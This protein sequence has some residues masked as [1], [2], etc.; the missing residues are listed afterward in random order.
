M[1]SH[2]TPP[3]TPGR[4]E[5][6]SAEGQE[7]IRAA[8][9]DD[10]DLKALG[11]RLA[12][13]PSVTLPGYFP[14]DF[15]TR[16]REN[17]REILAAYRATVAAARAGDLI[18]PAAEW[19]A[20]NHYIVE[21]N[22]RA[23]YRD[24]P[25]RFYRQLPAIPVEGGGEMPRCLA[26]AWLYVAHMHGTLSMESLAKMVEGFQTVTPLMIGEIWA[27]PSALRFV[28][29]ENL[30]RHSQ[31]VERARRMRRRANDAADRL[32]ALEDNASC[33]D[34]LSE[35]TDFTRDDTFVA[36]LLYRLR[37]GSQTS[38]QALA[39]LEERLEERDSDSEE[40]LVSE[41]NRVATSNVTTG[42]II[43]SLRKIND[44]EWTG[45]FEEISQVDRILRQ[46]ADFSEIDFASRD[47]YRTVI[48]RLAR[49]S[50][51]TEIEVARLVLD[52]VEADARNGEAGNI[53]FY[54]AGEKRAAIEARIGYRPR[55]RDIA[56]NAYRRLDWAGIAAPVAAI[57]LVV[58]AL[59]AWYLVGF[60]ELPAALVVILVL[61]F[62][63]P[64]SEAANGLFHALAT[65][66][67]LPTRLIGYE[68]KN[69]IPAEAHTLVAIP[70]LIGSKDTVDE[71]LRNLEVHYLA[72]PRGAISFALLSDWPDS[73]QEETRH[74][75]EI[76]D[77]ARRQ[78]ERLNARYRQGGR[79][80]FFL[81]HRRRVYNP[82]ENVWMGWE[83][84]RGKLHELNLLLRGDP[85]TTFLQ[86]ERRPPQ[87][88]RF[89]MTLDSDT[90]LTR[91]AVTKLVGKMAHPTNRPRL[92]PA[93]GIVTQGYGI[94]Q[95]RVTPSLT[96]GEEA[97]A[98]QR[99]FSVNRGLDPYV[100]TISDA[101][102]DLL[103]EGSFTGKGLYDID[104]FEAAI[105]G[106]IGENS[107]LSHDLLEGS[108]ARCGLATD[109]E[110]VE[111]FPT[112]YE[113]EVSRQHRW[114]R[115]DWQLLPY[116]F[117]L[118]NGVPMLGRWKMFDNLRR[119]LTPIVWLLASVLG[120]CTMSAGAAALWQAA[121]IFSLFVA[122]TLSLIS[123]ALPRRT[124]IV[125]R[126]HIHAVFSEI[127]AANAQV[128]LRIV[129]I[130]H[131]AWVM[132]DAI[133][134]T[135]YRTFVSRKHMLEWRT[136]AQVQ[137]SRSH[138][139][140]D[141][142]RT[143]WQAPAVA[144]IALL[145]C[146]ATGSSGIIVAIP[147]VLL[148]A[149]SPVMA[150]FVSQSAVTEDRLRLSARATSELRQYARR[151]WKFFEAFAN[152]ENNHLPPDNFQEDPHPVV[153]HRT[154]PTNIGVYLLSTIS[155]RDFGW[156]GLAET[157]RRLEDTV[158]TLEKMEK[159]R[160]HVF[161]WYDTR[162]LEPLHPRYVS[163]VDS[164]NLAG[165]LIA[166]S[167][168]CAEWAEAPSAHLYG[169]VEG[170]A[171]TAAILSDC[172]AALPDD[173]KNVRPL[174]R[175]VEERI[176]GFHRAIE[177][178][179]KEPE[180]VSIRAI[181]LTVLA[182]EIHRL[183]AN[184]DH[185]M[186]S[187]ESRDLVE[188]ATSLFT[189]CEAHVGDSTADTEAIEEMR[190]RLVALRDKTRNFAFSMDFA[191]L[192]R[193]E[194]RLLSIGY[195]V[196]D[197]ELDESCYDLLA[198]E[199]RL[200]SLFG[201]AKGDLPT[202]HWFRLGRPVTPVGT[203][204]ALVSW[205]GSMFEYLMPPLVMQERQGGIL[206]QS[207]VLAVR[208]QMSYAR[209]LGTPWGI[210]ESAFNARDHDL[211]YQYSNFGVPSL[212]LKRGLGQ[213]AVIAPYASLLACQY[214]PEEA[215]ANL[216]KLRSLG[217]LGRYGFHDAVDFT[218]TRVPE[219]ET[220][221]VVK[222]YM[223]HHEGMSV[224][225]VANV[226][227]NG[228]LRDR[229][230]ADPVIEA[231]ELLLQEK[232][233]REIPTLALRR[234]PEGAAAGEPQLERPEIRTIE[235]PAAA[236]RA[237]T[238]LSNGH[239]SVMV[240]ATGSGYSKW[241]GQSVTRWAPDP[242][243]DRFGTYIFLRDT[244][245]ND[246]WSTTVEPKRAADEEVKAVFSD[247]KVEFH[248]TVGTLRSQVECIVTAEDDGEGRKVTLFNDGESDRFIEVTSYA[249]LV[250]GPEDADAA[251]PA[252]SKMFVRTEIKPG[253][254]VIHAERKK[255]SPSDP[256]MHVVHMLVGGSGSSAGRE[257]QAETDRR[258]FLGRG[259][260]I[261]DAAAFDP[262]ARL[263][264]S[265]GFTLDPIVAL[266]RVVRVPAG[267]KASLIFWTITAPNRAEADVALQ[268]YRY[269]D[270]FEHETTHA[271]TRSQV[272]L[273]HVGVSSQEAATFQMLARYL[274]YPD[275]Q[276]RPDRDTVRA[277]LA[278]QL[279]LWPLA[280]SGDY[281]IFTLRVN[282]EVDIEIAAQA[283]LAQEYLRARGLLADLVILNEKASSYAQD[284]QSRLEAM[285]ENARLRGQAMGP[286]RHIF[287]VRR[288]L[289][290]PRTYHALLA[291]SR[292][293]F[294]AR[295]GKLSDQIERAEELATTGHGRQTIRPLPAPIGSDRPA[296]KPAGEG[297]RFWNGFGGFAEDG[298]SY[299]VRLPGGGATPH[300]WIN[301]VAN[302]GFGFHVSAEGTAFTWSRNSR[303]FQLT[304]WSNDPVSDR[305]GEA[306][307][308]ANLDDGS[309]ATP[310]AALSRDPSQLFEVVH[311]L[312]SS[313]FTTRKGD[314]GIE[315]TLTVDPQDPVR[316]TRLRLTNEGDKPARLRVYAYAEWVLGTSRSRTAPFIVP[317][318]DPETGVLTARNP[319]SLD[320]SART[321][322]MATNGAIQSHTADRRSFIGQGHTVQA[323]AV[324]LA[325]A[326][327]SGS[328]DILGDPCGALAVDVT[329]EAGGSEEVLVL[330]GDAGSAEEAKTLA[331][332]H[333]S[334]DVAAVAEA[335]S[336]R[337]RDFT[338]TVQVKTPDP[339][340]DTMVNAWLPY[341]S[342][343]CRITARSA[344]Y[345]AS[346]AFG[347]RDQ[348]QDTLAL[349]LHD[350]ALARSQIL[351]AAG[352]QFEKGDVQHWW[353]PATG[354]G[355]RTMI[356]DDVVWLGHA[357]AEYC[358]A[359]G[360]T[361]ILDE[362]LPFIA[363]QELDPGQHDA[364]F[365]PEVTT[366]V[367]TVYEHAARALDLA[368]E[369]TGPH[370]LPLF[371]GGDWNDGMNRVGEQGK[372]E[373]VWLG[374]FLL[375]TLEAMIPIAR[376]RRDKARADG[377]KTH[378]ASL[379]TALE[380][381]AWDGSY[382]LRGFYDDETPLGT[383][384]AAECRIDSIAQS[385][386]VL[387]G[388]GDA[389]R[390]R[391]AMESV[392]A[393]LVDDEHR[394]VRLFTPPFDR[395]NKDPGY[396]KGY[397]PGVRENGGQYTHAATWV[398]YALAKLGRGNEAHRCWS[399]LNPITHAD[400]PEAAELYRVEPYVVAAD[401]YSEGLR[402]GRGGWTWYTGSAGWL[403]RTAIE[404]I[405]G[406]ARRGDRLTLAP[407]LPDAWDGYSAALRLDGRLFE[408]AVERA[409]N[410]A[411]KVTVNGETVDDP[412][413]GILLRG[414]AAEPGE[415]KVRQ[416]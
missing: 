175:R 122:P 70:C 130:A 386:S 49:R 230:H 76:L 307:Y 202:D 36:Q 337:W 121:L 12:S 167:S 286:R 331:A 89:V 29:I 193:K 267:K 149:L 341:Q 238:L 363:G 181:N 16:H 44:I 304:P 10:A 260:T 158:A 204:A 405:L 282:D 148:W 289:M 284:L 290:E 32:L 188:W 356:A 306:L 345:Q 75:R 87:G 94:L 323:P 377:W 339:A 38:K 129:F 66:V 395:T 229:F 50:D 299:V 412:A 264:G 368:I 401:I 212:G 300:P 3:A 410:G 91:E 17:E 78:V 347:F 92:D 372:G 83:R 156:I 416:S 163:A 79:S 241:N 328:T 164:G 126:A 174:R 173:R 303:D 90:R 285:C 361:T 171:D 258:A 268:R 47:L 154:S 240:T 262:G 269:P 26:L 161:N 162:T 223:A 283:L 119:S 157:I 216:E 93:T 397:P 118:S 196:N 187:P 367:A 350:P 147:F 415:E 189:T 409:S 14:F 313:R 144:V 213:N 99:I 68:Y 1:T 379:K 224:A 52:M 370:G 321:V 123:G 394:L 259:R 172:L 242:T 288:D 382:Y 185:E 247:D 67:M 222:N 170:I 273:R 388:Q 140:L 403:Y 373:S 108:L 48:E 327:L 86:E 371:L 60:A 320:Y 239:Y 27:I 63:L 15:A 184:L 145:L 298:R 392:L 302:S 8:F 330:L 152:A 143:M 35:L 249:E 101:Y 2:S 28:L 324:V 103:G 359:T 74:D 24:L 96:T 404:G 293:V 297:L 200:T 109:V 358:R 354:A 105:K 4:P 111:D 146:A 134:R 315:A 142:L 179:R 169:G 95:P 325:G 220:C 292:V 414:L 294:H 211:N 106:R 34:A 115:G 139:P 375:A 85:D 255:R 210:S 141:Y 97:S 353:L 391:T 62:A 369:R 19:L 413:E 251:H 165:H 40:V 42:N 153:A 132:G 256:D 57:S 311:G 271:W 73:T 116:I 191:F 305:P 127:N 176:I 155:A 182:R 343:S 177:T 250:V 100:F 355:V 232:A 380:S 316:L 207:N 234:E 257:T 279:A 198:S 61:L 385:W 208:R 22:T 41:H 227:F 235:N 102:Q 280:I 342:L 246:W 364:F 51:R 396:I 296:V 30:R 112:R 160:G 104:A 225:A 117:N 54:L 159:F 64:A 186:Q 248:K 351:N 81:L 215:L 39:W 402:A 37:D 349:M 308:I 136:A 352:R 244:E 233:P 183:A 360:D 236:D 82:S 245:T 381:N 274:I 55:L 226:V 334:A 362:E 178:L 192:F 275:L 366:T 318:F 332:K 6:Q 319:Y 56:F 237:T 195:R 197:G 199:A 266:R 125:A 312:G 276:L 411:F 277:G 168:A 203:R 135:L 114:A 291:A 206:N 253:N 272:Q 252:F 322:F 13:E 261:A 69:G 301:V 365:P 77:Y 59:V 390:M 84:K 151:T 310:F 133:V 107:V 25:P 228:R 376:S 393:E 407:A 209:S 336:S 406:I 378:A 128:A 65:L 254:E 113:V 287:A 348:L 398:A 270:S 138:T 33:S 357:V 340:F 344:F 218:P 201:I 194:R 46:S 23:V 314:L 374:W 231:A 295:N 309:V 387:S 58:L 120:W 389:E 124:D 346:G 72:N 131:T 278:E 166:V 5:K 335:A 20:D 326:A 214:L 71:L 217:A 265:D 329:V 137:G 281:P 53:G 221:A 399:M 383:H 7:F 98:F 408:I 88:V 205:S 243:E 31:R 45:W 80:P 400:T 190:K 18:T 317:D 219:G 21:E 9:L 43:R 11:T 333:R 263:T 384:D 338:G 150:W 180:F 110:L